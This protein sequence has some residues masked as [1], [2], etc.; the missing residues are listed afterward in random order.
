MSLLG[1]QV[2]YAKCRQ[3]DVPPA[4]ASGLRAKFCQVMPGTSLDRDRTIGEG[5][6]VGTPHD[7]VTIEANIYL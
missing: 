4:G 2:T 5:P 7:N 6:E 1:S 3:Q